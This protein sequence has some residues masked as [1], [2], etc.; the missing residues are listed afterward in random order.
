[1][2]LY[3]QCRMEQETPEGK[4]VLVAWIE[5]RG[6]K[7]GSLVE[8]KEEDGLWLV[9]T[10]DAEGVEAGELRDKQAADRRSLQSIV[11]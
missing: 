2:T 10:A 3:H 9:T 6:A 8:L 7:V 4:V 5:K 11:H 1:V